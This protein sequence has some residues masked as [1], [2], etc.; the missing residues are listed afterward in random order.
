MQWENQKVDVTR[1]IAVVWNL[2]N[3]QGMLVVLSWGRNEYYVL[4]VVRRCL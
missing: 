3:L 1:F 2:Q 4:L